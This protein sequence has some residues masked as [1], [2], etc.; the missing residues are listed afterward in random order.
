MRN[1]THS[2]NLV[3]DLVQ[4]ASNF[5]NDTEARKYDTM[6]WVQKEGGINKKREG[7]FQMGFQPKNASQ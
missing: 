4:S 6:G 5:C 1:T 2:C 7:L 3:Q